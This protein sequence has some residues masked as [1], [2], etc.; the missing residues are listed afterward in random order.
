MCGGLRSFLEA[1]GNIRF[2]ARDPGLG[3]MLCFHSLE[4]VLGLANYVD[5]SA[6][7]FSLLFLPLSLVFGLILTSLSL[8]L[9]W[10]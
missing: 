10:L 8:A 4:I 5:G 9:L 1:Y 3:L 2:L 7:A 6:S